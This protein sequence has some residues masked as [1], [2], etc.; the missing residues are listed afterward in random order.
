MLANIIPKKVNHPRN[1]ILKK[2]IK[3]FYIK[4]TKIH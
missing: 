1:F 4:I 2:I 3:Y